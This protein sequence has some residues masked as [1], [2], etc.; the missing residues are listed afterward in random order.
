M[1]YLTP[2]TLDLIGFP[3]YIYERMWWIVFMCRLQKA[4]SVLAYGKLKGFHYHYIVCI[5]DAI[6]LLIWSYCWIHL[7]LISQNLTWSNHT[8]V[9]RTWFFYDHNHDGPPSYSCKLYTF[10]WYPNRLP[11][12]VPILGHDLYFVCWL[13]RSIVV[14]TYVHT[15]DLNLYFLITYV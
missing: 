2:K 7:H 1:V 13:P 3:F 10:V 14:M 9:T 12:F 5:T 11:L 6:F 15:V 4:V 8:L